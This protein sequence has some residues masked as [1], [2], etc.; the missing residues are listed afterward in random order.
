MRTRVGWRAGGRRERAGAVGVALGDIFAGAGDLR[1]WA[2]RRSS[3]PS[4]DD[5]GQRGGGWRRA[6]RLLCGRQ[7]L[8]VLGAVADRRGGALGRLS[9][10]LS[11]GSTHAH[12]FGRVRN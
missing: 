9:G 1:C 10:A 6:G 7:R 11:S 4:S 8:E 2:R 12:I 3:S 5:G